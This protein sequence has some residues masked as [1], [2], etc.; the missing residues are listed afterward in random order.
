MTRNR[1]AVVVAALAT[2]LLSAVPA[3]ADLTAFLG[4]A[5]GP[6]T[7]A[8]WGA[9]VGISFLIVGLEGEYADVG[10]S[11]ENGAPRIRTGSLNLLVQ[12]PMAVAGV[13][14]YGTAGAGGYRMTWETG[15]PEPSETNAAVN[16]GGGVKIKLVGPLRVRLDYRYFHLLGSPIGYENLHRFYVGGNLKF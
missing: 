11:V 3:S 16:F 1:A 8:G 5:G 14:L 15:L 7:R 10:Q 4:L 9:S 2:W 13:Q 6:S 12:T